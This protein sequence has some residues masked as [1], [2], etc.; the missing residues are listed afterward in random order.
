DIISMSSGLDLSGLF[1]TSNRKGKRFTSSASYEAIVEKMGEV[2]SKLGYWIEKGKGGGVI[3]LRKGR[4][5][6]LAVV[7]EIAE[8]LVLVEVKVTEGGV[9]S[10]EV[11]WGSWIDGLKEIVLSWHNDVV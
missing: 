6:M 4:L 9:D 2:G 8:S 7:L 11:Q 5:V 10:E 3:G 1:E